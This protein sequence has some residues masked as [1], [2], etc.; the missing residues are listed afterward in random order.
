MTVSLF[1]MLYLFIFKYYFYYITVYVVFRTL[2]FLSHVPN[3]HCYASG[4]PRTWSEVSAHRIWW[5]GKRSSI[6][7]WV[8]V[9]VFFGKKIYLVKLKLYNSYQ[10]E[11]QQY[12][13][14]CQHTELLAFRFWICCRKC[15]CWV[16]CSFLVEIYFIWADS[17]IYG[18]STHVLYQQ[19]FV[20]GQKNVFYFWGSH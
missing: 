10:S 18:V 12:Y 5:S 19:I 8:F 15:F 11:R 9:G 2:Y 17:K 3:H 13:S 16:E 1:Y 7:V 14:S 20:N 6:F 4:V